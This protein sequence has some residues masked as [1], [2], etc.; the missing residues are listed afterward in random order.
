[1]ITHLPPQLSE[2]SEMIWAVNHTLLAE[3]HRKLNV[4]RERIYANERHLGELVKKF[5]S[6]K[7]SI[8]LPELLKP[9]AK[10]LGIVLSRF[11][12][13]LFD[14]DKDK[15]VIV[16]SLRTDSPTGYRKV[17]VP[18]PKDLKAICVERAKVKA[19]FSILLKEQSAAEKQLYDADRKLTNELKSVLAQEQAEQFLARLP[20]KT[21]AKLKAIAAG[22]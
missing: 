9:I 6:L 19:E 15:Q 8:D 14:F 16:V 3:Q 13:N 5:D 2:T 22:R 7:D 12:I 11:T 20:K 1:M 17:E 10:K 4:L 21:I 18:M